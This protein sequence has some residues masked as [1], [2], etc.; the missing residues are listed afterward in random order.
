MKDF[1]IAVVYCAFVTLV[2]SV[3]KFLL[4]INWDKMEGTIKNCKTCAHRSGSVV[5]GKCILSGYYC[6]TERSMPS[7][8]GV[9]YDRWKQRPK[10][11]GLIN[12]VISLFYAK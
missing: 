6:M 5:H 7:V 12:W 1:R 11:K 4:T 8:C 10:R 9:D 3:A 2:M